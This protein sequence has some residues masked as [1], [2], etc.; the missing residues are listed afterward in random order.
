MDRSPLN[1]LA[2]LWAARIVDGYATRARPAMSDGARSV[3]LDHLTLRL[4][5]AIADTPV[6][7]WPEAANAALDA[8]EDEA[9]TDRPRVSSFDEAAGVVRLRVPG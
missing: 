9:R 8:W 4:G 7:D 1:L 3:L 6:G 5:P 2:G